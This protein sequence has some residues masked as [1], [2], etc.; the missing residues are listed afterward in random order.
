MPAS[1]RARGERACRGGRAD[2][3][4]RVGRGSAVPILTRSV[5]PLLVHSHAGSGRC[6][7]DT[8]R[9]GEIRLPTGARRGL[10]LSWLR[11][12]HRA[13]RAS[14]SL[15]TTRG[16]DSHARCSTDRTKVV[17][18]AGNADA[19][20]MFVGEAPG[21]HE[22]QQGLP[23]VGRAG[24][25]ARRAAR[26]DRPGAR[27]TSSSPT[28]SSA[29]RRATA[30]RSPRRSR[31]ASR[32][33]YTQDRADRA[34]GDLHAR[35]LRHQA[36]DRLQPT[37]ITRVHGQ[38]QEREL[39]GRHGA[40][41]PALPPG[42]GAAHAARCWSSCARTSRGC[43][44]CWRSRCRAAPRR[45]AAAPRRPAEVRLS[46]PASHDGPRSAASS[47]PD[48]RRDDRDRQRR[49]DRGRGAELAGG[50]ARRRRAGQRRAGQREDHLRARRLP[51]ARRRGPGAPAR[52]SR[53][54]SATRGASEVAHLDLYRLGSLAG[55]D[56]ACST[57]T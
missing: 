43:R 25:A 5:G 44:R 1:R 3:A 57:T 11:G 36:A 13:P 7:K 14:W 48:W 19:D 23:F 17:F 56:P 27:A 42:R 49:R 34:E 26:R 54:A 10:R 50:S 40:A 31:P 4:A 18:G 46:R 35:Q 39:G 37:G 55:E 6:G 15:S 8:A 51:R 41:L 38:P 20:L 2:H 22:D 53:S 47:P 24:Q 21:V 45:D 33:L 28:S 32:Y 30:T 12:P 9:S 52:R 29:A 16:A